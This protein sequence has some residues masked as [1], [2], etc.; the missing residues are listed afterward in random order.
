MLKQINRCKI[1]ISNT[2]NKRKKKKGIIVDHSIIKNKEKNEMIKNE[3][4]DN[5]EENLKFIENIKE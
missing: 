5:S 3:N 2:N 4:F 1:E